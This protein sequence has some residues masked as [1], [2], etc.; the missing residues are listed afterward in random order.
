MKSKGSS[1]LSSDTSV[2][3]G[4]F[5]AIP[6]P[7]WLCSLLLFVAWIFSP[8]FS[9]AAHPIDASEKIGPAPQS[10][11]GN[12]S[13]PSSAREAKSAPSLEK[14][15]AATLKARRPP[16]VPPPELPAGLISPGGDRAR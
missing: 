2:R 16:K 13:S 1:S 12:A 15:P 3:A 14:R 7:V 11:A 6:L 5:S 9:A 10:E 4:A 8:S